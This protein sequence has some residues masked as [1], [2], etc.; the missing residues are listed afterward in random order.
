MA[1][2]GQILLLG[3]KLRPLIAPTPRL[4]Y[5]PFASPQRKALPSH[6]L[7]PTRGL[8]W[9]GGLPDRLALGFE[10]EVFRQP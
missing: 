5:R 4:A 9:P 2:T 1:N 8:F 3:H 6:R 7:K 10:R